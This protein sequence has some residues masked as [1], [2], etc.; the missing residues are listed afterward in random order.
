MFNI[1]FK[2]IKKSVFF[3]P[4]ITIVAVINAGCQMQQQKNSMRFIGV[5]YEKS[6][7]KV[8]E[9][10]PLSP[11]RKKATSEEKNCLFLQ[12]SGEL[13]LKLREYDLQKV[14]EYRLF[15]MRASKR[16]SVSG[17]IQVYLPYI[18]ATFTQ[19]GL[20]RELCYLPLVESSFNPNAVSY[21]GAA[22]L[23]QFMPAT[24]RQYGLEV[25]QGQDER[26]DPYKSTHAAARYLQDLLKKFP[27][28]SLAVA[29]YNAGEGRIA[30][31]RD[32]PK[33]ENFF[34]L[35]R[36][37]RWWGADRELHQETQEYVFRFLAA[38]QV[39]HQAEQ[40]QAVSQEG[41]LVEEV[42]TAP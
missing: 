31:A 26:F 20:P 39:L 32:K 37:H 18:L 22:G 14:A 6:S 8:Q 42:F 27:D 30:A 3:I 16:S 19:Y 33:I 21:A 5:P 13:D 10:L 40:Q 7:P 41:V 29:A 17:W 35:Q 12:D 25:S 28:W 34:D 4:I 36:R 23:W 2:K 11:G 1:F 9:V 15:Y 38:S 24:A